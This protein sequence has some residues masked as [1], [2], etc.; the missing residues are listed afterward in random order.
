[1]H[2]IQHPLYVLRPKDEP[3]LERIY[4]R[5]AKEVSD[6]FRGQRGEETVLAVAKARPVIIVSAFPELRMGRAVRMVPL[7]SYNEGGSLE[8]QRDD[9]VK[10]DIPWGCHLAQGQGMH[11]GVALLNQVR[12][13]D[14]ESVQTLSPK[15]VA[16]LTDP[17]LALLLFRLSQY[18]S[19]M[20]RREWIP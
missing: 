3:Q 15:Q 2:W 10:G 12:T 5:R 6:A 17:S 8:R 1:V 13:S 9:I 4:P 14:W 16:S 7:Y 18:D 19:V 11:E 20:N